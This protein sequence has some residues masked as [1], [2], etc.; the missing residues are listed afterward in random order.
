MRDLYNNLAV[1]EA[2]APATYDADNTPVAIDLREFKSAM[3]SLQIGVGG[4]TF[5][6]T[7]KVEFKLTH[8]DLKVNGGEPEA[9]DYVAVTQ[10]D[11]QG[12]TVASGGIIKSLTAAHAA[13]SLTRVG[14]IGHKSFLK[15]LADFSGTHAAGTPISAVVQAQP[16]TLP[17]AA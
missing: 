14:Y 10:D 12:V 5:T 8:A 9:G 16:F 3:L 17:V 4:I 6:G 15:L 13:A 7:N 11:V 1:V 2:I